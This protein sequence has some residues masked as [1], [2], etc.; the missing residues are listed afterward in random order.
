MPKIIPKEKIEE[1][2]ELYKQGYSVHEIA[3][4][5][6]ISA[7]TVNKYTRDI[8]R[9]VPTKG[10]IERFKKVAKIFGFKDEELDKIIPN[11]TRRQIIN[12]N[13]SF[14]NLLPLYEKV[15]GNEINN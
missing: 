11:L 15:K 12:Y 10:E 2:R 14:V 1:A 5:V 7:Y 9:K 4:M 3:D 6:G 8:E 13:L